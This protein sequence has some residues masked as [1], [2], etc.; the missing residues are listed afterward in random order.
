MAGLTKLKELDLRHSLRLKGHGLAHLAGAKNLTS[1]NLSNAKV[2]DDE[3]LRSLETFTQLKFLALIDCAHVTPAAVARL[4]KALP[5]THIMAP[6]T[7]AR[8]HESISGP[9][10]DPTPVDALTNLGIRVR[11]D[12]SDKIHRAAVRPAISSDE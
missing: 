12:Q 7:L 4:K 5:R 6:D 3:G 1:I 2:L 10:L 8:I 11:W 9:P